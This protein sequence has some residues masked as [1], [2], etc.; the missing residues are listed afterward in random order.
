[1]HEKVYMYSVPLHVVQMGYLII[2]VSSEVS[3]LQEEGTATFSWDRSAFP[4]VLLQITSLRD[5]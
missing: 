1:M 3:L 5:I 4:S 2:G